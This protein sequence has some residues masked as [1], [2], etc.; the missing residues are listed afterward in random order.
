MVILYGDLIF[1]GYILR[2]LIESDRE[3]T[4]VV[5]SQPKSRATSGLPDY[6]FCS[7]PDQRALWGQDILL[8]S[9]GTSLQSGNRKADGRWIGMLRAKAQGRTWLE[10]AINNASQAKNF[11]DLSM[12]DLINNIISAGHPIRVIYVHGHWLDVN[13]LQDLDDAGVFT[14]SQ[15]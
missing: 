15:I 14:A 6:A 2:G 8:D 4:V 3:L 1:R 10:E 13:S 7:E 12:G 9:I 5:D 11:S